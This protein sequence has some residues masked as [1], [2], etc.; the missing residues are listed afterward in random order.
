MSA[1][2]QPAGPAPGAGPPN[3]DHRAACEPRGERTVVA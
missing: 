1:G 3:Q 2:A